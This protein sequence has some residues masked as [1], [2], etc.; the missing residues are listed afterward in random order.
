MVEAARG[1]W[2]DKGDR[3]VYEVPASE[4]VSLAAALGK[5]A[6]DDA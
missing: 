4:M 1:H 3:T 2:I 5:E 6:S